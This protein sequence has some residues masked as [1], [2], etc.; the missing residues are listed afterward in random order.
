M[1]LGYKTLR[2]GVTKNKIEKM[3]LKKKIRKRSR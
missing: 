3:R 1:V 2:K